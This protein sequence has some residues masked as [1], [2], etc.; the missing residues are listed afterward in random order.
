MRP[1]YFWFTLIE[2]GSSALLSDD[3]SGFL[4]QNGVE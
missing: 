2:D 4:R 1:L 3:E